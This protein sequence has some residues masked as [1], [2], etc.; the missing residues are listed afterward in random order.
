ML[1]FTKGCPL[2]PS[3]SAYALPLYSPAPPPSPPPSC[4]RLRSSSSCPLALSL[5]KCSLSGSANR[6]RPEAM[7]IETA[8]RTWSG[9]PARQARASDMQKRSNSTRLNLLFLSLSL[10]PRRRRK[11]KSDCPASLLSKQRKRGGRELFLSLS[12]VLSRSRSFIFSPFA[13]LLALHGSARL[14][15]VAAARRRRQSSVKGLVVVAGI[16]DDDVG[17]GK[18]CS[19]QQSPLVFVVHVDL[20][21]ASAVV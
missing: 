6:Y 9:R 13:L 16:S 3:S 1:R 5:S 21:A 14:R 10:S 4:C 15:A 17:V 11:K 20:C 19:G 7:P 8:I 12:L 2:P 18:H